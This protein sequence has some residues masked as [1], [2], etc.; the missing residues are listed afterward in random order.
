MKENLLKLNVDMIYVQNVIKI[1]YKMNNIINVLYVNKIIGRYQQT[2]N[3]MINIF[4]KDKDK[5]NIEFKGKMKRCLLDNNIWIFFIIEII[6]KEK[7]N[8]YIINN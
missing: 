1:Y 2:K 6:L 5:K 8:Y 7:K 3:N 4:N